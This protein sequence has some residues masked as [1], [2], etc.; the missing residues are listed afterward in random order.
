MLTGIGSAPVAFVGA[1]LCGASS[2]CLIALA[3]TVTQLS[4]PNQLR[5]GIMGAWTMMLPG[6]SPITGL[7]VGAIA[8]HWGPRWVFVVVGCCF[9]V[10]TSLSRTALRRSDEALRPA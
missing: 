10:L 7:A 1:V 5:G 2:I 9:I 6:M 3:N 8:D 4:S